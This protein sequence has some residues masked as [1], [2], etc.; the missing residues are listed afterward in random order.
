MT[1][2]DYNI[3]GKRETAEALTTP[4]LKNQSNEHTT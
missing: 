3:K 1:S 4:Y 2:E